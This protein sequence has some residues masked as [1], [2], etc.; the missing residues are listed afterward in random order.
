VTVNSR[1]LALHTLL[2]WEHGQAFAQD[3]LERLATKYHLEH[4][5][6]ALLQTLVF[7]VLRNVTLLDHWLDQVCENKHLEKSVHWLLRLGAAQ[8]LLI[9]IPPHAAVNE[10]VNLAGKA[11]GL[12]NAVL[13]RIEREKEALLAQLPS[14]T[15]EDRYSHPQWIIDRWTQQRGLE[16]TAQMCE[17]DQD[18]AHNY[19]RVNRLHPEALDD[20]MLAEHHKTEHP[21]FFRVDQ[22]PRDWLAVGK[23]YAQDPS[24]A[25]ACE[26]LAPQPGDFVLDAC[27]APGGKAAYLAQLMKNE[28]RIIAADSSP[29]RLDRMKSNLNRLHA[30]IAQPKLLNWA[31]EDHP[32]DPVFDRIL[33]DAP[34][35]NTGV[36]R[37]RI[38]VRWRLLPWSF[39]EMTELQS[40][41]LEA[42]LPLLKPGG[43]LVY[44]TCSI[45]REENEGVVET[46]LKSHPGFSLIETRESLPWRDGVDG[47]FAALIKRDDIAV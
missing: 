24:T 47:A 20:T 22:P 1:Q 5:D 17:W 25:M 44:S 37:R 29:R 12:T 16:A 45:D 43:S 32:T 13:R 21:D 9:D 39:K 35:S 3:I 28:G 46:V 14:L 40:S 30:K 38:D 2:E 36:M 4:R 42:T 6:T 41:I 11:R 27:A 19:I 34:C 31:D 8:L 7:S 15:L 18:P 10:C 26:L 33:V 23:C